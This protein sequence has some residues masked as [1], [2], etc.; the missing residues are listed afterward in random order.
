[1]LRQRQNLKGNDSTVQGK[2][3]HSLHQHRQIMQPKETK[4]QTQGPTGL[5]ELFLLTV[6]IEEVAR[7]QYI[8]QL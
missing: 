1:L 3:K 4:R 2:T 6:P 8:K 7:W 5:Y